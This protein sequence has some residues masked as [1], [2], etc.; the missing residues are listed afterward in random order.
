MNSY[1]LRAQ[2]LSS[3]LPLT[4]AP[5]NSPFS[6]ANTPTTG[7]SFSG[8]VFLLAGGQPFEVG[9]PI[10]GPLELR[11]S[12]ATI[13]CVSKIAC[14]GTFLIVADLFLGGVDANGPFFLFLAGWKVRRG[15]QVRAS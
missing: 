10:A 15:G 14:Q 2:G 11:F 9:Q 8:D 13:A 4:F 6:I 12:N 3:G 5:L 1:Q 7:F